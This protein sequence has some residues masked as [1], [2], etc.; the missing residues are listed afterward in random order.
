MAEQPKGKVVR[1]K[2]YL[3]KLLLQSDSNINHLVAKAL[4][5]I[6]I[7]EENYNVIKIDEEGQTVSFLEYLD[8]FEIIFV[9]LYILY[10]F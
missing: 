9:L 3:H 7:S 2:R 10:I 4:Q 8:F 5:Q 1:S 6:N